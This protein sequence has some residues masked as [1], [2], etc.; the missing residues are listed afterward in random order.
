MGVYG[1]PQLGRY[2]NDNRSY[3]EAPTTKDYVKWLLIPGALSIFTCGIGG[4]ILIVVWA[5]SNEQ[6]ARRNLMRA[7]L[8]ISAL[9]IMIALFLMFMSGEH[10]A[11]MRQLQTRPLY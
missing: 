9:P 6:P 10:A 5:C 3:Y 7:I 2:A 11:I 4:L 8:F 1:S